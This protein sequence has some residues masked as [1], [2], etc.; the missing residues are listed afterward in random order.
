LK[1][2]FILNVD[3]AHVGVAPKSQRALEVW[4]ATKE[5]VKDNKRPPHL[6]TKILKKARIR[7]SKL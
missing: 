7:E 1:F 4:A 2:G 5:L 6:L 3:G